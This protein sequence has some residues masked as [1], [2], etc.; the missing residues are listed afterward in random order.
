[1]VGY[2]KWFRECSHWGGHCNTN[3]LATVALYL[4]MTSRVEGC[5]ISVSGSVRQHCSLKSRVQVSVGASA[6]VCL[7]RL[8]REQADLKKLHSRD[9][10]CVCL[11]CV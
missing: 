6:S 7:T 9:G 8:R 4:D 3:K 10:E 11:L 1:M 5:R 2:V